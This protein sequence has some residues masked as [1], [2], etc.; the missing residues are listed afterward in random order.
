M[1][2]EKEPPK[3]ILFLGIMY[4][5]E[6]LKQR[7]LDE[8]SKLYGEFSMMAGPLDFSDLTDYYDSEMGSG[9]QK[10]YYLFEKPI[11][12]DSLASI[13]NASNRI[14][15][16]LSAT[17]QRMINLDPGYITRDK[18]V[19][20]SAKNYFHRIYLKDGIYAEVTLH[21]TKKG[22]R[23]FSWTYC[24]YMVDQVLEL[25]YTG[26]KFAIEIR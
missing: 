23:F 22:A 18:F 1:A 4:Q 15:K 11:A 8:F 7:A 26:R 24:D 20:A 9:I 16:E 14:E 10:E 19:L 2:T 3:A 17:G 21:F 25:L 5:N 12:T 13:K 6:E